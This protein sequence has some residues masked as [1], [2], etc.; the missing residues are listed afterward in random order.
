MVSGLGWAIEWV[1]IVFSLSCECICEAWHG[2]CG[3]M[4]GHIEDA[5][6]ELDVLEVFMRLCKCIVMFYC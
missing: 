1:V 3:Y 2:M 6:K 5:L 4:L